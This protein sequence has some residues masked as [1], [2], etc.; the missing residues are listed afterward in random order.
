[1][2][3]KCDSSEKELERAKRLPQIRQVAQV[4][5]LFL[6]LYLLVGTR[7]EIITILPPD[8]FFRINPLLGITSILASQVLIVSMIL[9]VFMIGLTVITGRTWCGWICPL[10]TILDFV[11]RFRINTKI[12]IQSYW[13]LTKYVLLFIIIFTAIFGSLSLIIFDPITIFSR[14]VTSVIIPGLS[15]LITLIEF[16]LYRIESLQTSIE[17]F[18]HMMRSGFL[19]DQPFFLPNLLIVFFFGMILALN[20]FQMRFWCRYLCPLGAFLGIISR[21]SYFKHR[22]NQKT[23]IKCNQCQTICPTAAINSKNNYLANPS[24]C[25][26]CLDCVEICPTNSITYRYGK[27]QNL[28]SNHNANRRQ[29]I[30]SISAAL[31]GTAILFLIPNFNKIKYYFIRPP[32][33]NEQAISKKCIRCGECARVCPTGVIQPSYSLKSLE[34]LWTPIL[35]TRL[36]YCDYSCTLCGEVCPTGAIKK[37]SLENK[38]KTV[39]GIAHIDEKKCIPWAQGVECIVCE[40][41]CPIPEKAIKL[42]KE[43]SMNSYGEISEV[44]LPRV[45]P[46]LCI[47]CGICEYKCPVEGDSAI[48][49]Y[50]EKTLEP[51]MIIGTYRKDHRHLAK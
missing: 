42:E 43:T 18:D 3:N 47:G 4:I 14:T 37:L 13:V 8:L 2:S 11:S 6:F 35:M 36:G 50:H 24:E 38:Q 30:K 49:V 51:R 44:L 45:I 39:I 7:K 34:V 15:F 12:K 29:L 27:K 9:E 46:E 16:S 21:I 10:G 40:E 17:Q 28:K 26:S 32:G 33:T 23:C 5:T 41:M 48:R 25:I 20:L 22:L 19:T 1:L 31:F